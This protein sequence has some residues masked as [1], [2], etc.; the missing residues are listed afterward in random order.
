[1]TPPFLPVSAPLLGEEEERAVAAVLASGWLSAGAVTTEFEQRLADLADVDHCV[2][3][4]SC[5]AA[6][7]LSLLALGVGP[8]D[9]VLVPAITF[10]ATANAVSHTGGT[11]VVVDVDPATL[12]IDPSAIRRAVGVRTRAVIP[13]HLAGLVAD[14]EAIGALARDHGLFIIEDAA[15][16]VG[17]RHRGEPVGRAGT[18]AA[19]CVSFHPT[20]TITA[21]EG[22]AVLTDDP[23]LADQVRLLSRGGISTASHVRHGTALPWESLVPGFKADLPD[24]HAAVGLSQLTRLSGFLATRARLAARYATL[25][26]HAVPRVRSLA[27]GDPG[28]A[29]HLYI[30]VLPHGV[31]RT[32]LR[33]LMIE[34]GIGTGIH[35]PALHVQA[36]FRERPEVTTQPLPVATDVGD[37]VL[38]L[39]LHPAMSDRDVDRVVTALA[40]SLADL[41]GRDGAGADD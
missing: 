41:G 13:V 14:L 19:T 33:R 21:I 38:T 27:A 39:P 11:P 17:G 26:P 6:L 40:D 1:M 25:L 22:G 3:V 23:R 9:E 29:W 24:V 16:A 37:R 7:H 12:T 20:K 8:G 15:H 28:R 2:A 30:V 4:S 32:R 10:P 18:A 35:F 34:R 31:D 36:S 5:T